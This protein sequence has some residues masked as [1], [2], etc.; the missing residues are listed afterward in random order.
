[1]TQTSMTKTEI[2]SIKESIERTE[3]FPAGYPK[4]IT[5]VDEKWKPFFKWSYDL[6]V[7]HAK[8]LGGDSDE[9]QIKLMV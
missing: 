6:A 1:M 7:S 5:D 8:K 4:L 3:R 2:A 9:E